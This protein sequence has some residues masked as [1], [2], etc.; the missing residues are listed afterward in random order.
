MGVAACDGHTVSVGVFDSGY[1]G[2]TILKGLRE[3][4]QNLIICIWVTMRA[5]RTAHVRL[6]LCTSLRARLCSACL[7][8]D[9]PW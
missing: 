3:A 7:T 9:A 4:L 6:T 1:G 5:H 2:L 8:R